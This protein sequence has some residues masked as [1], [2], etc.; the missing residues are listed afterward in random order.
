MGALD[1]DCGPLNNDG[2]TA[3]LYVARFAP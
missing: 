2:Q 1:L 3:D